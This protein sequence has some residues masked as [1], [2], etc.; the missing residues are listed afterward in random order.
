MCTN[1]WAN[2]QKCEWR[3]IWGQPNPHF[4][5]YVHRIKKRRGDFEIIIFWDGFIW[6]LENT[7]AQIDISPRDQTT[8]LGIYRGFYSH[9][10]VDPG[11]SEDFQT[12]CYSMNVNSR[13]TRLGWTWKCML[14]NQSWK[15]AMHSWWTL[16][17]LSVQGHFN[18][19]LSTKWVNASV[20]LNQHDIS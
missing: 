20:S 16:L 15:N 7:F 17:L 8:R 19:S 12:N 18:L 5:K 6:G 2:C 10:S 14:H 3:N 9:M 13:S 4:M 1:V 11:E